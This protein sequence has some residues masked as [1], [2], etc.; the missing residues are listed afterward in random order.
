MPSRQPK[1]RQTRARLS[2]VLL[3]SGLVALTG[4]LEEDEV[5]PTLA[6]ASS[7]LETLGAAGTA[8][9]GDE[10]RVSEYKAVI[11][12]L[13]PIAGKG[14][15]S[16]QAAANLLIASAQRGLA[17]DQSAKLGVVD[18]RLY[19]QSALLSTTLSQWNKLNSMA[20]AVESSDYS[21]ELA[22]IKAKIKEREAAIQ[23]E[24]EAT[25]QV[26]QRVAE[27]MQLAEQEAQA[28][29]LIR[30]EVDE[31]RTRADKL[32]AD[33]ALPLFEQAATLRREA[34]AHDVEAER[35]RAEAD[36]IRPEIRDHELE[37]NRLTEQRDLLLTTIEELNTK[38]QSDSTEASMLRQKAL[39]VADSIRDL[40]SQIEQ[41]RTDDAT[42]AME[43][44]RSAYNAA[45]ASA[46]KARSGDSSGAKLAAAE[47][48]H[49]LGNVLMSHAAALTFSATA[50]DHIATAAD[51]LPSNDLYV[52]AAA[53][54]RQDGEAANDAAT[55][56]FRAARDAYQ[57][58]SLRDEAGERIDRV[59][60]EL[61]ALLGADN[62]ATPEDVIPDADAPL[63]E[64]ENSPIETSGEQAASAE[65]NGDG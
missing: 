48:N 2:C 24:T 32:P 20:Q 50:I 40:V 27:L 13:K 6:Q 22:S 52:T 39:T 12:T 46:N 16:Q 9:P 23:A 25:E 5:G 34:D 17:Q 11:A 15:K 59:V 58:L 60:Q 19:D 1:F 10:F 29:A 63:P 26:R 41:I 4:C 45:L 53:A 7:R 55:E 28:A 35:R 65:D 51:P 61:D 44:A 49:E 38:S 14:S 31:L 37:T 18:Q 42:P 3:A 33:E 47:I 54:F 57:G 64:T 8:I 36:V 56:A 62:A 30:E 21:R 43:A